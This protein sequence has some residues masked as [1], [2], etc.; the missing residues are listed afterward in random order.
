MNLTHILQLEQL[1]KKIIENHI[2]TNDDSDVTYQIKRS[3]RSYHK[4]IATILNNPDNQKQNLENLIYK[5]INIDCD[6]LP[7]SWVYQL[8]QYYITQ[9]HMIFNQIE[10]NDN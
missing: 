2:E 1:F 5:M 3:Y 4:Q 8:K 6:E 10:Q 9:L 7:E